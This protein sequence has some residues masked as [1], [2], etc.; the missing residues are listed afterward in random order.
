V[1]KCFFKKYQ[2]IIAQRA[3]SVECR[4]PFGARFDELSG[5]AQDDIR[6]Y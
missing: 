1:E 3:I 6:G 5:L 4:F 2:D